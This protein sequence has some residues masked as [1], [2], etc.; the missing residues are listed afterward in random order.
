MG[1]GS[2]DGGSSVNTPDAWSPPSSSSPLVS[3]NT[4]QATRGSIAA[5]SSILTG[6]VGGGTIDSEIKKRSFTSNKRRLST[7]H[8]LAQETPSSPL[9]PQPNEDPEDK[10]STSSGSSSSVD[11]IEIPHHERPSNGPMKVLTS[12][13]SSSRLD[14]SDERDAEEKNDRESED[15]EADETQ[16]DQVD[17]LRVHLPSTRSEQGSYQTLSSHPQSGSERE[18]NQSHRTPPPE[19]S[20]Q[21]STPEIQFL[22]PKVDS[23][24][25]AP[26]TRRRHRRN[27]GVDQQQ[28]PSDYSSPSLVSYGSSRYGLSSTCISPWVSLIILF[29]RHWADITITALEVIF[30]KGRA[31]R[32]K[33]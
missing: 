31:I 27:H 19:R 13:H 4:K 25:S 26:P 9:S 21:L 11:E 20:P 17:S 33:A 8:L 5:I 10:S 1:M 28:Q 32:T 7:H 3:S 30:T 23:D 2:V 18:S 15:D 16:T 14:A 6:A 22:R 24:S 29:C 12:N